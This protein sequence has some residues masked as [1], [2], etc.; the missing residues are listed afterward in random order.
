[1]KRVIGFC[2]LHN[3]PSLGE[4]TA[5]RT[6]A[7]TSFL[8][9]FAFIDFT[10]SNFSNSGVDEIG[11]LCQEHLRSL[12]KH[13]GFQNSW[14]I[15]TKIGSNVVMYNEEKFN[16]PRFN[17][18]LNNIRA[19]DWFLIRSNAEYV[20]IAPVHFLC[21]ID[22][23]KV[24]DKHIESGADVTVVYKHI[25]YAKEACI[26]SNRLNIDKYNCVTNIYENG[27][28]TN[29][30]DISLETYVMSKAY[31][32][33]ILKDSLEVSSAFSLTEYLSHKVNSV[34]LCAYEYDGF[35]RCIDSLEKY[36]EVS[37]ELFSYDKRKELF[38]DNWPIYTVT[39]DTPPTRYGKKAN[40]SNSIVA[41]GAII[42]GTVENSI[43]SRSVVVSDGAKVTN[44]IILTE[45]YISNDTVLDYC[46]VD[47]YSR[48]LCVKELKGKKDKPLYVKQGDII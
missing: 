38:K 32:R 19:N 17:N 14:N 33:T 21:T 34:N 12:T 18:D 48:I 8:G 40:V 27:G 16:N 6:L 23:S 10:L 15:N 35:V 26:G 28:T 9:R 45:T 2:N 5:N 30:A 37:L 22:F 41:N 39:H 3:S 36:L 1:M 7:S 31:L 4:L 43:I 24:I 42:E 46:I 20:V 11:I 44:S 47:K 25:D 13:L 29:E